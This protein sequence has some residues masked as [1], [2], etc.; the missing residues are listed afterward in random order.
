MSD[1]WIIGQTIDKKKYYYNKI[2]KKSQWNIP[3]ELLSKN[4]W[5]V[6]QTIDKQKYYY[7][8]IT[9]KS[10]W[11]IP[12]ELLSKNLKCYVIFIHSFKNPKFKCIFIFKLELTPLD[13]NKI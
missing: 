9:K 11:K 1:I 12:N 6:G 2:T 5:I 3:N 8:K 13:K 4:I 10:Q 7:N